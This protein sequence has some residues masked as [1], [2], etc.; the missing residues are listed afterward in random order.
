MASSSNQLRG[1]HDRGSSTRFITP[2]STSIKACKRAFEAFQKE[3]LI[4]RIMPT[5]I[6]V[7]AAFNEDGESSRPRRKSRKLTG[8]ISTTCCSLDIQHAL[9]ISVQTRPTQRT[10]HPRSRTSVRRALRSARRHSD[11]SRTLKKSH[12]PRST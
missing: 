8:R 4:H 10:S 9:G 11:N 12:V 5:A 2:G 6:A 7:R 3:A 1:H